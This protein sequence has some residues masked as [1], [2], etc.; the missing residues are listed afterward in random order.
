[1]LISDAFDQLENEIK[2]IGIVDAWG[3]E[4]DPAWSF[5]LML[6]YTEPESGYLMEGLSQKFITVEEFFEHM[7][8]QVRRFRIEYLA[9]RASRRI[10]KRLDEA[11]AH[12]S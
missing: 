6:K 12:G 7:M 11:V 2:A 4:M 8:I 3:E 10:T 5:A 9:A 1:M